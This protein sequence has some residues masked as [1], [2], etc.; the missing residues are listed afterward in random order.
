M[1]KKNYTKDD[2]KHLYLKYKKK[3]INLIS[4]NKNI[5]GSEK[6]VKIISSGKFQIKKYDDESDVYKIFK[7]ILEKIDKLTEESTKYPKLQTT[8][9]NAIERYFNDIILLIEENIDFFNNNIR[10]FLYSLNTRYSMFSII[11]ASYINI[12]K[13]YKFTI[14]EKELFTS[15]IEYLKEKSATILNI[16]NRLDKDKRKI[17]FANL[18][19]INKILI[20]ILEKNNVVEIKD[21][22]I[23]DSDYKKKL[24]D[25]LAKQ[26]EIKEFFLLKNQESIF[27]KPNNQFKVLLEDENILFSILK[28]TLILN[29]DTVK[30]LRLQLYKVGIKNYSLEFIIFLISN[31]GLGTRILLR[32]PLSLVSYIDYVSSIEDNDEN[33]EKLNKINNVLTSSSYVIQNEKDFYLNFFDQYF[34]N[35]PNFKDDEF[36]GLFFK[37]DIDVNLN[38]FRTE[39]H[40]NLLEEISLK[41]K[42]KKEV[43]EFI[44]F[45]QK[46][47]SI[48]YLYFNFLH[49]A[50]FFQDYRFIEKLLDKNISLKTPFLSEDSVEPNSFVDKPVLYYY[51]ENI[52]KMKS[53]ILFVSGFAKI[54]M[55]SLED[56]VDII[57][58]K[59]FEN[60]EYRIDCFIYLIKQKDTWIKEGIIENKDFFNISN[61]ILRSGFIKS[62][63]DFFSSISSFSIE[64]QEKITFELLTENPN[65]TEIPENWLNLIYLNLINI[66]DESN[67]LKL[68]WKDTR[69]IK[70]NILFL[71]YQEKFNKE[72]GIENIDTIKKLSE[73]EDDY[74]LQRL[75]EELEKDEKKIKSK[76][77]RKK[78]RRKLLK[79]EKSKEKLIEK[80]IEKVEPK[81]NEKEV[82]KE[83]SKEESILN[84]KEFIPKI[85]EDPY[86][87]LDEYWNF[88]KTITETPLYLKD[89]IEKFNSCETVKIV[90]PY[91][92]LG[93]KPPPKNLHSTI[94]KIILILGYLT[95]YLK[96]KDVKILFKGGK[97]IQKYI[98]YPS[99]DIDIVILPQNISDKSNQVELIGEHILNFLMWYFKEEFVFDVSRSLDQEETS[100]KLKIKKIDDF[101]NN[102]FSILDIGTK[103]YSYDEEIRNIFFTNIDNQLYKIRVESM[104]FNFFILSKEQLINERKYLIEKLNNEDAKRLSPDS[105]GE[106]RANRAFLQKSVNSLIKLIGEEEYKKFTYSIIK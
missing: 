76:S 6:S 27:L 24:S 105:T 16:I 15:P 101:S 33:K 50:I 53:K 88:L 43:N 96:S 7:I 74:Q 19:K 64:D 58:Q 23:F 29:I 86:L 18:E 56:D 60:G 8:Y 81:L 48:G 100:M 59:L 31:L 2:Y 63:P 22:K 106:Q 51:L 82:P 35:Y 62:S 91:Y 21:L 84:E 12:F 45:M 75:I 32:T 44:N 94:C 97:A 46:L 38:V 13:R 103:F 57:N 67:I 49:F 77:S 52:D 5:G 66:N 93:D 87:G 90:F 9:Q 17:Q 73:S 68:K 25:Y 39:G 79:K 55:K 36:S 34:K 4:K 26:K 78:D 42:D 40:L 99:N 92:Q 41:Y 47:K 20:K 3:Y 1:N 83:K 72:L 69:F 30:D 65:F 89:K 11:A 14:G 71:E 37:Y 95:K 104:K 28:E 54:L 85:V 80:S 10:L 70:E 98:D 102:I 61:L